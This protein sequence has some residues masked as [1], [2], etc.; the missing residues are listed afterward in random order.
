LINKS[1]FH[2]LWIPDHYLIMLANQIT[3]W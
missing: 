2:I 1:Q 3:Q